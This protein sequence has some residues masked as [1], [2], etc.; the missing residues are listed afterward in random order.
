MTTP[1]PCLAVTFSLVT[2]LKV[3]H[4][5]IQEQPLLDTTAP[6][7]RMPNFLSIQE[8]FQDR[9][10]LVGYFTL[11]ASAA[12]LILYFGMMFFYAPVLNQP[13]AVKIGLHL[14]F[15]SAFTVAWWIPR[16]KNSARILFLLFFPVLGS[17]AADTLF[18][19]GKLAYIFPLAYAFF[20]Y[21]VL[22]HPAATAFFRPLKPAELRWEEGSQIFSLFR[23]F[24]FFQAAYA[25]W[26]GLGLLTL[27]ESDPLYNPAKAAGLIFWA[28]LLWGLLLLVKHA[29]PFGR[30][31]LA[32]LLA[33][34]AL[35]KIP[36]TFG[37]HSYLD[38][39]SAL[40]NCSL[41]LGFAVFLVLSPW[42]R[43]FFKKAAPSAPPPA[44]PRA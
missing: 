36:D 6:G 39:W 31:T 42:C 24:F 30:W 32:L 41:S 16:H 43:H 34:Q 11:I 20:G 14:L 8:Q 10:E 21:W 23:V 22:S 18:Q 29:Q 38:Y 1:L 26:T 37:R 35:L 13:P 4:E 44:A 5:S 40:G 19:H 15:I 2:P 27:A 12:L 17:Y 3:W 28:L 9:V 25:L 33:G 7:S